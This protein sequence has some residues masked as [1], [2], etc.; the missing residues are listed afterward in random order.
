MDY[1]RH[2][3]VF[4]NEQMRIIC[5]GT[6]SQLYIVFAHIENISKILLEGKI[7]DEILWV[8]NSVSDA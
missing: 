3:S 8:N 2:L 7:V 1:M 4:C 5:H 6:R